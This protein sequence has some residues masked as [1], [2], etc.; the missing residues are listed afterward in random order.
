MAHMDWG[1]APSAETQGLLQA[2]FRVAGWV[3]TLPALLWRAH[4]VMGWQL[5]L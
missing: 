3:P 4:S 5:L 2:Q 1:L